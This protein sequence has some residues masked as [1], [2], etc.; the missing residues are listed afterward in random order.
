MAEDDEARRAAVARELEADRASEAALQGYLDRMAE[1]ILQDHLSEAA[2]GALVREVVGARTLTVL[3]RLDGSRKGL[4]VQFLYETNLIRSSS[5][6]LVDLVGADLIE[7]DLSDAHLI[8]ADLREAG[9]IGADLSGAKSIEKVRW[10]NTLC[11]N[12]TLSELNPN[13][14]CEG[15]LDGGPR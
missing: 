4:A 10:G 2:P 8:G 9:L 3:R 12:A 14:S 1:L 7:A 11:P 6:M 5:D 13:G 15:N